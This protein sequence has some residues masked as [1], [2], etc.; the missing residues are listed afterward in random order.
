M[1]Y[2]EA[3]RILSGVMDRLKKERTRQGLSL[4]RLGALSGVDRTMIAKIEKGDRSP[5]LIVC[6]RVADALGL[7]LHDVLKDVPAKKGG[8]RK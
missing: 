1:N 3:E 2:R 4:Q 7:N 6:L 8:R 5:T